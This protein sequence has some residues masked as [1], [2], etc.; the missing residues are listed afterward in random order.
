MEGY[1]DDGFARSDQ[2]EELDGILWCKGYIK[3]AESKVVFTSTAQVYDISCKIPQKELSPVKPNS[4]YALH[5]LMAE[6][7]CKSYSYMYMMD[8]TILRIFNVYG[9]RIF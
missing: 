4:P 3:N 5:K 1:N 2:P 8:V 6:K 7:I 9:F